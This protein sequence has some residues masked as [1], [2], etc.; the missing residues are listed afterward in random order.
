MRLTGIRARRRQPGL[1]PQHLAAVEAAIEGPAQGRVGERLTFT[2]QAT[3]TG[4]VPLTNVR[5]VGFHDRSLYPRRASTGY[6]AQ[7]LTRGELLWITPQLMPGET[8]TRQAELECV[9]D[10]ASGWGRVFVETAENV[11]SS[12]KE[13]KIVIQPAVQ[14]PSGP[15]EPPPRIETPRE[16]PPEKIVGELK[17]SIADRQDPISVNGTMTY[18]VVV[19]NGRNVGDK[20]VVLTVVLPPGLEFVNLRGPVSA[21]AISP[22]GRT[23]EAEPV[24]EMR[25]GEMLNPFFIEVKGTRIGKHVIKVRVDS[26]RSSSP[27]EAEEDTTVNVSG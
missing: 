18:I 9:K 2:L 6:D 12:V 16:T 14:K 26:F 3:N 23:V 1:R 24:K 27:A 11:R 19:E 7:A 8:V 15:K 5:V 20:N 4:N 10:S 22:D 13:A 21:R 17:V 25:P